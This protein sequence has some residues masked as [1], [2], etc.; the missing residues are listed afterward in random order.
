M[1]FDICILAK[2]RKRGYAEKLL[3]QVI[4]DVRAYRHGLVLTCEDKF[5]HY[6]K[7]IWI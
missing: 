1:I 5:I 3:N 4:S 2:Y 7:K 6:F